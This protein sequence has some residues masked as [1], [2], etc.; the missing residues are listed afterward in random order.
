MANIQVR[1]ADN[2]HAQAQAVANSM[3]LTCH[4]LCVF[5]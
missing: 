2:L 1:V 3:G 4:P 5:S